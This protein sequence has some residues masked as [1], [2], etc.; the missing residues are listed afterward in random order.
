MPQDLVPEELPAGLGDLLG[1]YLAHQRWFAGDGVPAQLNVV[2]SAR[3]AGP[4]HCELLWAIVNDGTSDYQLVIASRP[5]AEG[6]EA[7]RGHD[8]AIIGNLGGRAY[9]DATVD[10]EMALL[11][12]EVAS[13]GT[14]RAARARPLVAEQSNTSII[15]DDRLILKVFRRL[16]TRT[17]P[18]ADVTASLASTGFTHIASPLVRWQREG[19]DLAFGQQ[20]LAG[21]TDGWALALTSLRDY[22]GCA[23]A[24][25]PPDPEQSGGDFASEAAR[26][27]HMT[28]EMH[29]AMAEAYG[30][31]DGLGEDWQGLVGTLDQQVQR[32]GPELAASGRPLL[33]R[34]RAVSNLGRSVHVHGDYHLGQVMRSDSGWYVLDF[35]GEPNRPVE[36][37]LR[38]SSVM[39]DVAG[40]LRSLHYASRFALG[41]RAEVDGGTLEPLAIAWENRNSTAFMRG[42]YETKSIEEL[43]PPDLEDREALRAAFELEKAFYEVQYERSFRPGWAPIPEAALRRLLT[44]PLDVLL[45]PRRPNEEEAADVEQH[46]RVGA[47]H[48][49]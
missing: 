25:A 20:F 4:D 13:G 35:E 29:L 46:A 21:G 38:P 14:E 45:A 30:T 42:Y 43:L 36:E 18:D 3:A 33:E 10:P 37:R 12:L 17:N 15:Y 26:L 49:A 34:L 24:E 22:Y 2:S 27:G 16:S 44:L 28:G 41:E 9:Y 5:G 6:A 11:L 40:M 32:L 7:A 8:E 48:D 1:P 39:K 23:G 31:S 19:R 47:A